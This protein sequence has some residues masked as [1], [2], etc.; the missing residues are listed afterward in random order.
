M[1][2]K[3]CGDN[4]GKIWRACPIGAWPPNPITKAPMLP[5]RSSAGRRVFELGVVHELF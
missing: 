4:S 2:S 1:R 3:R 5:E